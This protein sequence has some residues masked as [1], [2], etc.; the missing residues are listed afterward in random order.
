ML[1]RSTTDAS[2][3]EDLKRKHQVATAVFTTALAKVDIG[4]SDHFSSYPLVQLLAE[5]SVPEKPETLD[6][7]LALLGGVAGSLLSLFGIILLWV[8]KPYLQRQL[9]NA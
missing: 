1:E 5:P 7:K 9:K 2:K 6:R 3:L 4:K 8:R